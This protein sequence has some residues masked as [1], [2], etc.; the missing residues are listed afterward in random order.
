MSFRML[1][2]QVQT[3]LRILFPPSCAGCGGLVESEFGL[4][5]DCWRQLPL[6]SGPVCDTCGVPVLVEDAS[7]A[8]QCDD[9]ARIARPWGRG[10]AAM[11]YKDMGRKL[12]LALKHGDR[13]DIAITAATWLAR[14]ARPI[15]CDDTIL[16]PIPLHWS[17]MVKRRYNQSALLVRHLGPLLQRPALLDGLIRKERTLPLEGA[18]V[19][20]RFGRLSGAI[21]ANPARADVIR[22]RHVLIVDDVLTSGATFAAAA[23]A[24]FEAGARQVDVLALA[25]V[26]KDA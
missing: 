1:R 5:A 24:S 7:D 22:G 21:S 18:T 13:Q 11:R 10:R 26:C 15:L 9:C 6:I 20:E 17:R 3:A 23:E 4:C 12:V 25:R 19:E 8:A 2:Q 14:A 16:V